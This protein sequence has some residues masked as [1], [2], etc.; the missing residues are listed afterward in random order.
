[1]TMALVGEVGVIRHDI[2]IDIYIKIYIMILSSNS[3]D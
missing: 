1:M 3:E 2:D